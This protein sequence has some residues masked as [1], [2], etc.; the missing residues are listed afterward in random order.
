MTF[1]RSS[2]P[3]IVLLS[4]YNSPLIRSG[5]CRLMNHRRNLAISYVLFASGRVFF[6]IKK[7]SILKFQFLDSPGILEVKTLPSSAGGVGS[8]PD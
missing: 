1:E 8:S 6:Y 7:Q 4:I 3:E 5:S 2:K